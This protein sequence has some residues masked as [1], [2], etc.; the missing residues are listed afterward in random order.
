MIAPVG[1]IPKVIG[2]N[3][4]MAAAGPMP[5]ST[6]TIWPNSTP[7][8][9]IAMYVGVSAAEK[10]DMSEENASILDYFP[11]GPSGNGTESQTPKITCRAPVTT[12]APTRAETNGLRSTNA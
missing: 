2:S 10:P 9:H 1:S 3:R 6:P 4:A 8:K 11:N 7:R 12:T 5:G